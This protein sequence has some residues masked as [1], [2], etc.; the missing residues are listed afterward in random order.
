M[1]TQIIRLTNI[2]KVISFYDFDGLLMEIFNI[3]ML[4]GCFLN[5]KVKK[6]KTIKNKRRFTST[7]A[8]V[9]VVVV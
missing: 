6:I 1:V 4:V 3:C 5:E 9:V 8:V 2:E 7:V